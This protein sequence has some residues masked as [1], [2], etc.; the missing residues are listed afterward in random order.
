MK[1]FK[2]ASILLSQ[3]LL[4]ATASA[5]FK[6]T[7]PASILPPMPGQ[8][9]PTVCAECPELVPDG[10]SRKHPTADAKTID[11]KRIHP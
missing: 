5:D 4:G 2:V 10:T 9:L 11:S 6:T 7:N 3:A 8:A 1:G